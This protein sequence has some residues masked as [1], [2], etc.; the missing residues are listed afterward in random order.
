MPAD[1]GAATPKQTNRQWVGPNVLQ[2]HPKHSPR[3]TPGD[4]QARRRL[5]AAYIDGGRAGEAGL[6]LELCP[7]APPNGDP[8]LAHKWIW[9]W[10]ACGGMRAAA[11]RGRPVTPDQ[12]MTAL[13]RTG[14]G[15]INRRQYEISATTYHATRAA[16]AKL[17]GDANPYD[18]AADRRLWFCWRHSHAE[19][20][21]RNAI[22]YDADPPTPREEQI[23]SAYSRARMSA[24][25]GLSRSSNPYRS[26]DGV[27]EIV[28]ETGFLDGRRGRRRP[29]AHVR[30][31][32]AFNARWF[33]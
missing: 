8:E 2:R 10:A 31:R 11:D 9:A 13:G 25:L 20:L 7:Y 5:I 19:D 3:A 18:P 33:A 12:F 26:G 27:L 29:T 32:R 23:L 24:C 14:T 6:P 15:E 17:D 30:C 21:L 28:W 22:L 1:Q 16:D 4:Q